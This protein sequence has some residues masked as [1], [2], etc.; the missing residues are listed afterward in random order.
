MTTN[1]WYRKKYN[2]KDPALAA[3]TNPI[4]K[5]HIPL[6]EKSSVMLGPTETKSC[7]KYHLML[8]NVACQFNPVS[9]TYPVVNRLP[10]STD[11]GCFGRCAG[12]H[13]FSY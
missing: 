4:T 9:R 1:R 11:G 3:V 2:K 10:P 8:F 6:K 13:G 5:E 7:K 12:F